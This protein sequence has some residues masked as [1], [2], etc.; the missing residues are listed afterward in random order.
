MN[1]INNSLRIAQEIFKQIYLFNSV[2]IDYMEKKSTSYF[3]Y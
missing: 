1:T 2:F 3:D